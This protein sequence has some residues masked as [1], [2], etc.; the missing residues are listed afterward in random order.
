MTPLNLFI[1]GPSGCGKSTQAKLIADKYSL[2][3]ISMGQVFRDEM[4]ANS[5]YGLEAKSYVEKGVWVP[6]DLTFDMLVSRIKPLN[7]QNFIIDG[8]P[9]VLNQGKIV[10]FFLKK[11]QQPFSLLIHL[12]VSFEEIQ[13]RRQKLGETFQ[14][15]D[16]ID[17]TPETIKQRQLTYDETI[18]PI[19]EY[20]TTKKLFC[21]VDGNRPIEPIFK[22]ICL[23]IDSL[24]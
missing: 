7:F 16:R 5:G 12:T 21:D 9:R 22:D 8:F 3:H 4:A 24:K 18:G 11:Q 2:T 1:I 6:D 23:A 17:N 15:S 10:E 19:K 20:F 13:T 14:E